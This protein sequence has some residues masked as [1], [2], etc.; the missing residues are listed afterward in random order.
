[1]LLGWLL[2][3]LVIIVAVLAYLDEI[4]DPERFDEFD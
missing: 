3:A 4:P 2:V 1:M